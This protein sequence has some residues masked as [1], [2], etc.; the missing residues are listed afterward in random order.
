MNELSLNIQLR[1]LGEVCGEKTYQTKLTMSW[2]GRCGE[3][4]AETAQLEGVG[5]RTPNRF[6]QWL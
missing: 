1:G 6:P 3:A 4:P 2:K 5:Y